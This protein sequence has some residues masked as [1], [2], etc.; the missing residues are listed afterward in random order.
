MLTDLRVV[1]SSQQPSD[2]FTV[3]SDCANVAPLTGCTITVTYAPLVAGSQ[4]QGTLLWDPHGAQVISVQGTVLPASLP[5]TG[6]AK[7]SGGSK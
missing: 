4:S 6:N 3:S 1:D 7:T 2:V 5:V